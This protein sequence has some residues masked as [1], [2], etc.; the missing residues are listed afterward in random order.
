MKISP[1]EAAAALQSIEDSQLSM[2]RAIRAHRGHLYLWL[3]GGLWLVMAIL[4]WEDARRFATA[5]LI[6]NVVGAVG[7]FAI[8]FLQGRQIRSPI[9]RRFLGVCISVLLFGYV[10][11]PLLHG[12][13]HTYQEAYATG[14][15]TWMQVYIIGGIW[16]DNYWLWIGIAV[17]AVILAGLVMA[18]AFFWAAFLIAA[19]TLIVS[20]FYV[21][22]FWR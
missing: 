14:L 4:N 16:F 9:D 13:Y 17:T 19:L 12:G 6:L 18:P 15:L 3:W 1:E 5:N 21:R 20:G 22:F 11:F 10:G 8:G 7:S 2:R